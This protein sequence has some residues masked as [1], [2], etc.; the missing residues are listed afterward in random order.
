M[1][2]QT[3]EKA[4]ERLSFLFEWLFNVFECKT[5]IREVK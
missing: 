2:I 5:Y 1:D 3:I 4:I